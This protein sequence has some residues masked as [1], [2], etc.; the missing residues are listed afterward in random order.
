MNSKGTIN[1]LQDTLYHISEKYVFKIYYL[2]EE[3]NLLLNRRETSHFHILL[4][5]QV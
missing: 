3:I 4:R 2:M 5:S 1:I